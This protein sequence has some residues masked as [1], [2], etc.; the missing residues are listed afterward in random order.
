MRISLK[1]DQ[2]SYNIS[3][4]KGASM[5]IDLAD[6]TLISFTTQRVG[7]A[8]LK[9]DGGVHR[10]R[11]T[12]KVTMLVGPEYKTIAGMDYAKAITADHSKV[13]D[14]IRSGGLD[15]KDYEYEILLHGTNSNRRNKRGILESLQES[16]QGENRFSTHEETY[17]PH[18]SGIRGVSV[19]KENE[20]VYISGLLISEEI[21]E[22]DPNGDARKDKP[23]ENSLLKKAIKEELGLMSAK[24]RQY[25]LPAGITINGVDKDQDKEIYNMLEV[26][27][28]LFN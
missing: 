11:H 3:I 21:V 25:K 18:P 27:K 17:R 14:T 5:N 4:K 15:F 8:D 22:K 10:G 23:T 7:R 12:V 19:H 2:K 13:K 6:N 28:S 1:Y 20:G 24:W 9:R 26:F 16:S